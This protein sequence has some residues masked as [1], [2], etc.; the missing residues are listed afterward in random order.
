MAVVNM[1]E[2]GDEVFAQLDLA[3]GE[4]IKLRDNGVVWAAVSDAGQFIYLD[5]TN[6][7]WQSDVVEDALIAPLIAQGS[8]KRFILDGETLYGVNED[9]QLWKYSLA[10]DEFTLLNFLPK[11]IDYLTDA[12]G[13]LILL[14][15]VVAA[16]K[17]IVELTLAE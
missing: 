12:R 15:Y 4:H 9:F 13:D 17:E 3:T 2:Q 10:H 6:Q 8:D 16:K 1:L 5:H 14:T 7:Y 11:N